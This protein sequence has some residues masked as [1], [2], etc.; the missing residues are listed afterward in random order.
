MKLEVLIK[1]LNNQATL[2]EQRKVLSWLEKPGSR[3]EFDALLSKHWEGSGNSG[4]AEDYSR[5]LAKIHG[6][7]LKPEKKK[8]F[9]F[10]SEFYRIAASVVIVL[11]T[12][13]ILVNMFSNGLGPRENAILSP[14]S[15]IERRTGVGE[16]MTLIM[17]DGSR[18]ILN[19]E[20]RISFD[21]QYGRSNRTVHLDGE[22]FFEVYPDSVLSFEVITE[23]VTT[24]ALGTSFNV[25]SRD[26][27]LRVAL[28]SGRVVVADFSDSVLLIPGQLVSFEESDNDE[29]FIVRQFNIVQETGWKEG[30]LRFDNKELGE[31]LS[32]LSIWYGVSLE[33]ERGIELQRRVSGTFSN[34]NLKDILTGLSFSMDFAFELK[35]KKVIIKQKKP[36]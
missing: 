19:G 6:R 9:V 27:Q 2:D 33:V 31:I 30:K 8:F 12:G 34:T 13:Y 16:K 10:T 29:R 36:M 3:A 18:I 20:S 7:I 4:N 11:F 25:F 15:L 35:N 14:P 17:S 32:D 21:G 1:F 26:H 28:T 23:N 24:C 22:A 5:I